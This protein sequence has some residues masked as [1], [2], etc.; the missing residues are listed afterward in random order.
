MENLRLYFKL[1][2][3]HKNF[4]IEYWRPSWD[5]PLPSGDFMIRDYGGKV[6][7]M[8]QAKTTAWFIINGDVREVFE[9]V[10]FTK[11]LDIVSIK[12]TLTIPYLIF[13]Y[14]IYQNGKLT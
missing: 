3:T 14:E 11:V 8:H 7:D 12:P 1:P 2:M 4:T 6:C 13:A 9:R 10:D 5:T